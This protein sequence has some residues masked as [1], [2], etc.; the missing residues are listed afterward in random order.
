RPIYRRPIWTH[1]ELMAAYE[2]TQKDLS[3]VVKRIGLI[4]E[5][6]YQTGA[7]PPKWPEVERLLTEGYAHALQL[8]GERVSVQ[9]RT[10]Q[11]LSAGGRSHSFE[12][13][14]LNARQEELTRQIR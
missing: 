4:F 13:R 8:E 3:S 1:S 11:L 12:L 2:I 6:A 5:R 14:S 10:A 7:R 9:R